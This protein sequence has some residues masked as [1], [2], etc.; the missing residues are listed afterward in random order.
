MTK[1]LTHESFTEM[2][3]NLSKVLGYIQST[4]LIC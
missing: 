3:N 4:K 1:D 2:A